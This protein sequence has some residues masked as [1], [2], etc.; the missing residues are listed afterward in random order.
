[1]ALNYA[2]NKDLALNDMEAAV[3]R[4]QDVAQSMQLGVVFD[5]DVQKTIATKLGEDFRPYRILGL[6]NPGLAKAAIEADA[7][8]G[9]LLP[10]A[11]ALHQ[12]ENGIRASVYNLPAIVDQLDNAALAAWN[13]T[14]KEKLAA[15]VNAL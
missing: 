12:T 2:V 9:A 5:I 13:E 15:F 10:C 7:D 14:V 6:C 11:I 8:F 4:V 3:E 1:M